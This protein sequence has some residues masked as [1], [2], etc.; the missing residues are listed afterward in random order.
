MNTYKG[1]PLLE[2]T[3]EGWNLGIYCL[4]LVGR[5]ATERS[6]ML[7]SKQDENTKP[8]CSLRFAVTD[9]AE[10]KVLSVIMLADTPIF[11]VDDNGNKFYIEFSKDVLYES[12]RR[13]LKDG[14]QN[15]INIEHIESS[16]VYGF[17]MAQ[18]FIKD[19]AKGIS[20][21]GFEDVPEGSLFG[22]FYVSDE[23]LW[24][25]I[26]DGKFTGI[27]L[28]GEYMAEEKKIDSIEDL[29]KALGIE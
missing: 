5:P 29:M 13:M 6:W 23:T 26:L 28:E 17:D 7:F 18:L 8:V 24:Q 3:L 27:S 22:E 2:A 10:H 12:A 16:A 1:L 19:T 4:S 20:P 25:E 14:F 11:R 21:V 9:A 15:N